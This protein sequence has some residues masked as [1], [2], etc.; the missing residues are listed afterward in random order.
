MNPVLNPFAPGAGNRPP[1]LAGRRDILEKADIA[2]RRIKAG[3]TDR[4]PLFVGLSGVGKTVVLG[5]VQKLADAAGCQSVMLEAQEA[6]PIAHL[7]VPS[8]R[9]ILLAFDTAQAIGNAAR[10]GLRVLKSFLTGLKI[11]LGGVEIVI[12]EPP[13][14]GVAD[15]GLLEMDLTDVFVTLGEVAR[16]ANSA[17][18]VIIDELQY[19]PETELGALIMAFHKVSQKQLPVVLVGAGLPQL[20]GNTG[21]AKSYAERLFVFPKLGAL[22]EADTA[23]ALQEPVRASGVLFHADAL[24]EVYRQTRGYPYFLQEWGFQAWNAATAQNIDLD[25]VKE[26][27]KVAI[28]NL[29]ES[30]FRVRFDRL[31]PRE[32]DY[33]RAM[34]ELGAEPQRS[35]DIS[36]LLGVASEGVAPLRA[37]LISKG[38]IYSPRHGETA[39]TVPLFDEFMKRAMP[40]RRA[41]KSPRGH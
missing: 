3:H 29:D 39:F 18:V 21:R 32:Q 36:R 11:T 8:L 17:A 28:E 15:S 37:G 40:L 6:Q 7:L 13:E 10:R 41:N 22:S 26:A 12:D 16:A 33:L 25:T 23:S 24:A 38:M 27:S 30:F 31:T 5:E 34:A 9:K 4:S 1:E 20:I 35:G 19:L 2:I 14:K